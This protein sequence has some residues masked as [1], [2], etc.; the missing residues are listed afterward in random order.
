MYI[1]TYIYN[2]HYIHDNNYYLYKI[3]NTEKTN[4]MLFTH[5]K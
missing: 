3:I 2:H 5:A 1:G 4:S